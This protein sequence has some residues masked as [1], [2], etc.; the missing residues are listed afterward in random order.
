[1]HLSTAEPVT[2]FQLI[3]G[4]CLGAIWSEIGH[5]DKKSLPKRSDY[6]CVSV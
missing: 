4:R 3:Q 5:S 2:S 1:M 6:F